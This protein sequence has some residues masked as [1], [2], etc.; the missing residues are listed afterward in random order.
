MEPLLDAGEDA[1]AGLAFLRLLQVALAAGTPERGPELGER[2][3]PRLSPGAILPATRIALRSCYAWAVLRQP[4]DI[5]EF[6]LATAVLDGFSAEMARQVSGRE[7][8][9]Q[10]LAELAA[11]SLVTIAAEAGGDRYRHH[12]LFRTFLRQRLAR[13]DPGRLAELHRRAAAAWLAT[14]E[15]AAAV[16]HYLQAGEPE[17]AAEALEPLAE[18]MAHTAEAETLVGWLEAI[19][20]ELRWRHP[21]LVLAEAALLFDRGACEAYFG[22][23]E[24]AMEQLLAAGRAPQA[25]LVLSEVLLRAMVTGVGASRC[26]AFGARLAAHPETPPDS[27]SAI[28]LLVAI[29]CALC[30]RFEEAEDELQAAGHGAPETVAAAAHAL[31]AVLLGVVRGRAEAALRA[32]DGL[33]AGAVADVPF[34]GAYAGL[35]RIRLL[36]NL[37][38]HEE[39][40]AAVNGESEPGPTRHGAIWEMLRWE[41]ARALAGLERW[42][43]LEAVLPGAGPATAAGDAAPSHRLRTSAA[44]LAAARRNPE[45]VAMHVTAVRVDLAGHD[46][47]LFQPEVLCDLALAA[48]RAGLSDQARQLAEEACTTSRSLGLTWPETRA[49]LL[50]AAILGA[51]ES[52][53]ELLAAALSLTERH[54]HEDL[55]TSRER[56]HAARLLARALEGSLGPPGAAAALVAACGGEVMSECAALLTSAPSAVRV[57]L[58][59]LAGEAPAVDSELLARLGQDRDADVRRAAARSQARVSD[60]PRPP[61]RF[62]GLGGFAVRRGDEKVANSAFGRQRA[63]ALLAALLCAGRPVHREELLD[64]FWS[65][66]D[67]QR[68]L[69]AL[70]VTLYG[71]RRALEPELPRGAASSIIVAEGESY[72]MR[73]AEDDSWDAAD[74]LEL[75]RV[76]ART[77]AGARRRE[78]LHLAEA[79]YTGPLFPEWPYE[80]WGEPRQLEVAEALRSTL[81]L[82]A[83]ELVEAGAIR[84]AIARYERLTALEPEREAWHRA[85]MVTYE[86][87]GERALA[88]RQ[89]HACRKVLREELGV[90][91]S[92]ETRE[93]HRAI[94]NGP[95]A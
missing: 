39:A 9:D 62:I 75:A 16:P 10:M 19:P 67:A 95:D 47:R 48:W 46:V 76:A 61:L 27:R 59:E 43:D 91:T 30:G 74:F 88:L 58:A 31:S 8:A 2:W 79:S 52:G 56:S 73:P 87:A 18:E 3:L 55:W 51:G 34:L 77:E 83:E 12:Q 65:G 22:R 81:A 86:R 57:Q 78:A 25:G 84:D 4:A 72:R 38:R 64:W 53:D 35:I 60:R 94:L 45:A 92:A 7:D 42:D 93:L 21:G 85:L 49:A 14:G 40:L 23:I 28:Q 54:G 29:G 33:G 89:Y 80:R 44:L 20:E 24:R 13:E 26:A 1:R 41:R 5:Q 63:R 15:P 36:N 17:L 90:E 69:R 11:A 66:L 70:H 32:L 37:G 71:L 82:L 68:G 50:G 6:L